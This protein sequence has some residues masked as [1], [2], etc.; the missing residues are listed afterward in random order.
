MWSIAGHGALTLVSLSYPDTHLGAL[1]ALSSGM[2]RP[3]RFA[4]GYAGSALIDFLGAAHGVRMV[5][6]ERSHPTC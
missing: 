1:R 2:S 4:P 3:V 5:A 6:P